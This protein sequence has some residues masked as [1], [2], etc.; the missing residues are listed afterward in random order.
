MMPC[1]PFYNK[2]A[3]KAATIQ[4]ETFANT[5]M[6]RGAMSLS[7]PQSIFTKINLANVYR[8]FE[9]F[10]YKYAIA[11]RFT[12]NIPYCRVVS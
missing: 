1:F 12:S 2:A 6:G 5:N 7:G 8:L 4:T 9:K 10:R 11:E 3:V